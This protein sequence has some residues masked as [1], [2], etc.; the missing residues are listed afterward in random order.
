MLEMH[1]IYVTCM[2]SYEGSF[3][4]KSLPKKGNVTQPLYRAEFCFKL[5]PPDNSI[6]FTDIGKTLMENEDNVQK[7]CSL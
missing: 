3:K 1:C 7:N 5:F 6:C 2:C 4:H